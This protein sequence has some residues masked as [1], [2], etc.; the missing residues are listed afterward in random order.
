MRIKPSK[1]RNVKTMVDGITFHSKKEAN[2][3][4]VLKSMLNAGEIS[5]LKLQE[6]YRI[7]LNGVKICDYVS[8]FSYIDKYGAKRVI[9]VKGVRTAI[10]KLKAKLMKAVHGIDIV[11]V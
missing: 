6:R 5:D 7:E 9:D 8:D 2:H 3:Y 11:E 1:Y 10:Y 4:L